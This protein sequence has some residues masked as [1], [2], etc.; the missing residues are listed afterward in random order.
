MAENRQ[1]KDEI[2]DLRDMVKM[3]KIEIDVLSKNSPSNRYIEVISNYRM[4]TENYQKK[5]ELIDKKL[6]EVT[7]EV[8]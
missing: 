4:A 5:I 2:E 7:S 8:R 1:L 6:E 3:N